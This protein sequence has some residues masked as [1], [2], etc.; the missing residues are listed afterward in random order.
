MEERE[1]REERDGSE[2]NFSLNCSA[3]AFLSVTG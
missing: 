1:R 2:G 3:R